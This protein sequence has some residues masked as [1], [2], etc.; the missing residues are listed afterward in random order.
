VI[1]RVLRI[2]DQMGEAEPVRVG[3]CALRR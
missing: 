1:D 3:V 2:T